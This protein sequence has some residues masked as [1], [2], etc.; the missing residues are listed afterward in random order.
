MGLRNEEVLTVR[1]VIGVELTNKET[2]EKGNYLLAM[3]YGFPDYLIPLDKNKIRERVSLLEGAVSWKSR[4]TVEQDG[5]FSKI[6]L[7]VFNDIE[8]AEI[9]A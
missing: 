3:M 1:Y 2:K 4:T 8:S 6:V 9:M 7:R 5:S